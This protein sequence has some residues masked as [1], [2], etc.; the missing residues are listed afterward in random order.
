[1]TLQTKTKAKRYLVYGVIILMAHILQNT[2]LTIFPEILSV[3]PILLISVAVCI[4]MFEGEVV[5]A[6][7]GFFAGAL[8]D[9]VT[10]TADGYNALFLM[11]MCAGCGVLLRIFMRNNIITYIMMNTA[12]TFIYVLSYTLFFVAARGIDGASEMFLKYYLP[13]AIY[14]LILTPIWYIMI[15]AVSR[16]FSYNYTEY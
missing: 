12:I 5:G 14:S 8:W 2:A 3:R 4:S 10:V 13:M 9:T 11:A 7:A 1:M 16:K 6:I 15:R